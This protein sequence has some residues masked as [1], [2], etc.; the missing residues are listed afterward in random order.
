MGPGF[1]CLHST[2]YLQERNANVTWSYIS[3]EVPSSS[4]DTLIRTQFKNLLEHSD[5]NLHS[6]D[7]PNRKC[8]VHM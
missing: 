8:H 6:D 7:E 4:L 3:A 1:Y 5:E 2:S